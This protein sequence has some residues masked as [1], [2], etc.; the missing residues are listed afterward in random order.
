VDGTI[1]NNSDERGAKL[2]TGSRHWQDYSIEADLMLLGND[3]D[4]GLILRSDNEEEGVDSYTGYYAGLRI[5]GNSLVIGRAEYGWI[6]NDRTLDHLQGGIQFFHWYHLKVLAYGCQIVAAVSTEDRNQIT[7]IAMTDKNCFHSGRVG[8]RSYSSGGVWKNVI[9]RPATQSDLVSMLGKGT[10]SESS[11]MR[12]SPAEPPQILGVYPDTE[13]AQN[14]T[15]TIGANTQPIGTLRLASSSNKA[16]ATVRGVVVLT[17]PSLFVQDPTGG[18]SVSYTKGLHLKV[19]D[20]VEV[21]G[22]VHPGAFSSTI[23]NGNV[24]ILWEHTPTPAVSITASQAATGAFDATFVEMEGSLREK[25]YGPDNTLIFDF[26]AG[27]QSFRA[28]LSRGRGDLLFNTIKPHSRLRLRGICTVDSRYTANLTPFVLLL[29]STDDLKVLA[30]PPWWNTGHLIAVV[31][32]LLLLAFVINFL[33]S[34]IEHWRFRAV[35]EERERLAHEMHDTLAQSF[36]GIGFQLEAIRSCLPD[37]LSTVHQQLDLASDLVHHSHEEARRRIAAL[38]PES[39]QSGDLL[40]ALE[41]CAQRLV[42]G[43]TVQVRTQSSGAARSIPPRIADTLYRI[44]QEA[45]ANAVQHA[46]P[47]VITIITEYQRNL[48]QLTI[49]DD[50]VGFT[51]NG[52]L[53]GFGVRGI[54][55]RASSISAKL[56][57]QSASGHGTVVNVVASLPP[58]LTFFSWPSFLWKYLMEYGSNAQSTKQ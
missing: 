48:L 50:G 10:N 31:F 25:H 51:P 8:L 1:R 57:I 38:Q 40:A 46:H 18:A 37:D 58:R 13:N 20:E 15:P 23:E 19:G 26:D 32:G 11:T 24:R 34:R 44:G 36:A 3:G 7:S 35:V 42:E 21:S 9:V 4:A 53:R 12:P 47:D 41:S 29:R 17:S 14:Q 28:I 22:I 33:Y 30:G 45:I 39:L 16:T 27:P 5:H 49:S 56:Q 6:E 43:G 2:L 52:N 55:K 54:R